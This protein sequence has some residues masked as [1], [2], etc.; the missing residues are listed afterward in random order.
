MLVPRDRFQGLGI[1]YKLRVSMESQSVSLKETGIA[2]WTKASLRA[3][4]VAW[5]EA[6]QSTLQQSA[7]GV[8]QKP[9]KKRSE[10]AR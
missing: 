4:I 7:S 8:Y 1:F 9:A 6:D 3:D 5:T 2:I 10:Q